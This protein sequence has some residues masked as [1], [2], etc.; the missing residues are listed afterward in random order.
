MTGRDIP[1]AEVLLDRRTVRV[2]NINGRSPPRIGYAGAKLG[3]DNGPTVAST[4][5][6]FHSLF[7]LHFPQVPYAHSGDALNVDANVF[8]ADAP[9]GGFSSL[10][11]Q[12]VENNT[13]TPANAPQT[14]NSLGLAIQAD[15]VGYVATIQ[16][17]TPPREF[18]LLM[19]SGSA[20][21]W[22][23]AEGCNSDDGNNCVS[24]SSEPS[25]L[26]V[27][28]PFGFRCIGEPRVFGITILILIR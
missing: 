27:L 18:N 2:A 23:G 3:N 8:A 24:S 13:L 26:P 11:E 15:D 22:V 5:A 14:A 4:C 9:G 17:G 16:M 21:L 7:L 10:D 25:F 20:D 6:L 28:I 12:A 19:D 1:S